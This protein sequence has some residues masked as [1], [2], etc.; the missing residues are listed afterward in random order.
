MKALL[1]MSIIDAQQSL[2]VLCRR[3]PRGFVW[4]ICF[5]RFHLEPPAGHRVQYGFDLKTHQHALSLVTA[6]RTCMLT[7][8]VQAYI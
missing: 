5:P 2:G 6:Y 4:K 7:L 1:Q 3:R 8:G